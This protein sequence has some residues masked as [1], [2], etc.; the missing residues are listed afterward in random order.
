[1]TRFL[2]ISYCLV[3]SCL[4]LRAENLVYIFDSPT[5]NAHIAILKGAND[6][7]KDFNL[8]YG[9]DFKAIDSS[10]QN[11]GLSQAQLI[12]DAAQN[13][14]NIGAV[15]IPSIS[16]LD[17]LEAQITLLASQKFPSVLIENSI[18]QANALLTISTESEDILKKFKEELSQKSDR[19]KFQILVVIDGKEE[20][21]LDSKKTIDS[22]QGIKKQIA[23][24]LTEIAPVKFISTK[25]F[26]QF[27]EK[28]KSELLALDNYAL[29]FLDEHPLNDV[30][31]LAK[32][33]D[34]LVTLSFGANPYMAYYLKNDQIN[35][36]AL[37]DYYGFG[38]TSAIA[39][40]EKYMQNKVP[41]IKHRKLKPSFFIPNNFQ[42]FSESWIDLN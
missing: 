21:F 31:P 5:N 42:E 22:L 35:L 39:L 7:L 23:N 25:H 40:V 27:Q 38:Y 6:A 28:Y 18:P 30:C 37:P 24:A 12:K 2:V 33:T 14:Q 4:Y 15:I 8:R 20:A 32:D 11:K 13:K 36:L 10:L 17:E 1:M 41:T 29:V 34:R 16:N 9:K 3:L 19:I 26:S